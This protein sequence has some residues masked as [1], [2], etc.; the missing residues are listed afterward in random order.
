MG[1]VTASISVTYGREGGWEIRRENPAYRL[2]H[3]WW[4]RAPRVY[5]GLAFLRF[6]SLLPLRRISKLRMFNAPSSSI[7]TVPTNLTTEKASTYHFAADLTFTFPRSRRKRVRGN[8]GSNCDALPI[9]RTLGMGRFGTSV[10]SGL[11]G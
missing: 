2:A 8:V 10:L 11:S 1:V 7:P 4:P 6:F 5:L 9:N 3:R